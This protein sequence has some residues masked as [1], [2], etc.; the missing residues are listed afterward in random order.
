MS[1]F[2]ATFARS[3]NKKSLATL[4]GATAAVGSAVAYYN[5]QN[6]NGR[7]SSKL[8]T[9]AAAAPALHIAEAQKK[10]ED[11]QKVYNAIALKLREEDEYDGGIGYGPVLVRLS[12][13]HI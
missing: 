6:N 7:R 8:W 5:F 3:I 1:A 9:A 11:Y 12:L 2:S 4:A 13:I 10:P